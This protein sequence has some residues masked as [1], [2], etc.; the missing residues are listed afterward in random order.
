[1]P[2]SG[3]ELEPTG[4]SRDFRA[5]PRVIGAIRTVDNGLHA[6][7]WHAVPKGGL[8]DARVA[9]ATLGSGVH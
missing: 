3:S 5:A 8:R 2:G 1:M 7:A 9:T 6:F 4:C